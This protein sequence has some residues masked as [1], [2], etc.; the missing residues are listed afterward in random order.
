MTLK[1]RIKE[2]QK[3]ASIKLDLKD[4]DFGKKAKSKREAMRITLSEMSVLI[5][6]PAST[7]SRIEN[8]SKNSSLEACKRIESYLNK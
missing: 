6:V 2:L 5:N 4:D 8:G 1:D 7:I 3:I